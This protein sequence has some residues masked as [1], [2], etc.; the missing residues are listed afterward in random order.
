MRR[1]DLKFRRLYFC[2]VLL[3]FASALGA[4]NAQTATPPPPPPDTPQDSIQQPAPDVDVRAVRLTDVQ[5][6]VQILQGTGE[7]FSQAQINMPIIQGMKIVTGQTGQAEVQFE[8]GSVARIT[9][10]SA[11]TMS[12]LGHNSDG[13][14]ETVIVADAGLTY[15][16]LNGRAGQYEVHFVRDI[17]VPNASS[18]FR[19]DL[20]KNPAELAVMHG[21]MHV[22][23]DAN[24]AADINTNQT[25]VLDAQNPNEYQIQQSVAANSWDQWNSD[26]D[27]ALARLGDNATEA[28]AGTENPDN[29][30]WSDLDAYGDWY[31]VPGYG[32]GWT[33]SGV[34]SDWDPYGAG[35]WGYY[36]SI[37]YTWISSYPWGW[38]PYHC[39]G[40]NWFGGSGWMWFPGSCGW[41]G[42]GFGWYP[43]GRIWHFPPGYRCPR[44]PFPVHGPTHLPGPHER[45]IAVNR[46]PQFTHQSLTVG[47][48]RPEP[49]V[50]AFNGQNVHPMP[51]LFH[52][53]QSGPMGGPLGESFTTRV[54]RSSPGIE[55][56]RGNNGVVYRAPG[57]PAYQPNRGY[58]PPGRGY[59]PPSRPA[60]VYRAPAPAPV[61]HPSPPA[62]HPSAPPPAFHPAAPPAAAAPAGHPR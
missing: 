7:A 47:A 49:R 20:D 33:P 54:I 5:G 10:N 46:G 13:T 6:D 40:W 9:P 4:A 55:L 57:T 15:Y 51:E 29:P 12:E 19:I 22:S 45:L 39:G 1:P 59:V 26:R 17:A 41:A 56:P 11:I 23:N 14:T 18:I 16:E 24:L 42:V 8:D 36:N 62:Y 25:M 61:Y 2:P 28:R 32:M 44:R 37:G 34:G 53:H 38:W 30:A 58:V 31:D 3:L 50:L 43:Y 52:P 60:P 35:A 48:A 21:S 27:E